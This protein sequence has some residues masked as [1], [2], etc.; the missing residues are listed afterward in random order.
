MTAW[1]RR[2]SEALT[3]V[4]HHHLARGVATAT[5]VTLA[6]Q[7][8]RRP[9]EA[10]VAGL[11]AGLVEASVL[12]RCAALSRDVRN[13][14]D[15]ALMAPILTPA[16]MPLG[17]WAVE[18]D[19]L[20]LLADE[21]TRDP[22]NVVEL[23]SGASTVLMAAVRRHRGGPPIVSI[24]HESGFAARTRT[25]LARAGL[26]DQAEVHVAGLQATTVA[27]R[28]L[29]WYD[30]DVLAQVLPGRIDLLVVDGPPSTTRRAR[31]PAMEV[32][33]DRLSDDCVI[34]LDDG[35][36]R[37]ETGTVRLWARRFPG[38]G[39]FW[40]DTVKGTWRLEPAPS[41]D[42]MALR[43]ARRGLD[44]LDAHPAGFRRW[45]VRR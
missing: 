41:A 40:H 1:G 14:E 7:L 39:L 5:A 36:R 43:W 28:T 44:T 6:G 20:R 26:S 4:R 29:P 31:W 19:F 17:T 32:L 38:L 11:A 42:G 21:L 12:G 16:H 22:A 9:R 37:D 18:P 45:P 23:G 33:S 8:L 10:A 34:L 2:A 3:E 27:G 15:A 30:R 13:A 25:A 24:D 35:R